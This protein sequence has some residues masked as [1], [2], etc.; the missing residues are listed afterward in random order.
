VKELIDIIAAFRSLKRAG[1]PAA[2]AT[3][4]KTRG[5]TYRRPG[6][7]MLVSDV[8]Q[9]VGSVSGGCLEADVLAKARRLMVA[10]KTETAVYD[11]TSS[12]KG[13]W[14]LNM[15]C[16]GVVHLLIEPL[17]AEASQHLEFIDECM[18]REMRGVVATVFRVDGEFKA[19]VGTRLMTREDGEMAEN[20]HNPVLSAALAESAGQAMESGRSAVREYRFLEG[21]VEA[22]VEVVN[23]PT[24]LFI[25]G[26]GNDAVPLARVAQE[27]GWR[28][29]V[30]DHRPVFLTAERFPHCTLINSRPEEIANTLTLTRHASAVVMTHNAAHDVQFLKFLLSTPSRY[31]GLLGPRNRTSL[32]LEQLAAEGVSMSDE[33]RARLFAPVGL[34]LGAESPEEIALAILAEIRAVLSR[35]RGGFLRDHEGPIH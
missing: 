3:V 29:A 7:R 2:L 11:M 27:L 22:F 24:P 6:A 18:K 12:D 15:G 14:G 1:K 32:L 23:P 25:F 10:G 31:I 33:Q 28:V 34:D 9:M 16:N 8:G 35:R 5:S 20:V 13:V 4:V 17:T 19:Q 26:A 30:I 21:V